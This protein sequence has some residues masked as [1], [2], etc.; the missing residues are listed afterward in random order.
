MKLWAMFRVKNEGRWIRRCV[1]AVAPLCE[2]VLVM[3]DQSTDDTADEARAG[4]A[5]VLPTPFAARGHI[6]EA[7]D[8]D[9]L[10]QQVWANGAEIGDFVL[11]LDGDELLVKED[12]PALLTAMRMG[13][14]CGNFWIQYLWNSEGQIRVDRWYKE[15]RR[16]SFFKLTSRD[17]RF[18]RTE[19]GGNFHCSSAPAQLL[20]S[21][22]P[23]PV[24]LLHFGYMHREDRVRKYE[25]YNAIDGNNA[26]EDFYRHVCQGDIPEIPAGARL[27]WAGPL[28]LQLLK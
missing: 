21:Q 6:H 8:K 3:D 11:C 2:K 7:A 15:F 19:F 26:Y 13:V 17:L 12:V 4:G 22:I 10:L 1:E 16:P 9:W 14:V 20:N 27:K 5:L 18:Q 24:R 23:L 28:E 25:F